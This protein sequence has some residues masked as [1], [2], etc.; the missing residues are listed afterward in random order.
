MASD[1]QFTHIHC[2]M[3]QN[4]HSW[5]WENLPLPWDEVETRD[6]AFS[7]ESQ[8]ASGPNTQNNP[9]WTNLELEKFLSTSEQL[10]QTMG[11]Q[12]M[13]LRPIL[14]SEDEFNGVQNTGLSS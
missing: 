1:S 14:G 13:L 6:P 8:L 12:T 3:A 4:A 11:D 9:P 10:T 5:C 7:A 2:G